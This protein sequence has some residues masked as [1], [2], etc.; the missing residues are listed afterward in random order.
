[1]EKELNFDFIEQPMSILTHGSKGHEDDFLGCCFALALYPEVTQILRTNEMITRDQLYDRNVI[2]MDVGGMYSR[3]R[4]AFDH[5]GVT[6]SE[7]AATLFLK[8]ELESMAYKKARKRLSD[9]A[10]RDNFGPRQ[11]MRLKLTQIDGHIP[12]SKI[13][14]IVSQFQTSYSPVLEAIFG[15]W[16]D[17]VLIPQGSPMYVFM[18]AVGS[19]FLASIIVKLQR[20]ELLKSSAHFATVKRRDSIYHVLIFTETRDSP[21]LMMNEFLKTTDFES[22]TVA[23]ITLDPRGKGLGL[24]R[25]DSFSTIL[26]FNNIKSREMKF[27]HDSGFYATTKTENVTKALKII[28][29]AFEG[30]FEC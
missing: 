9:L 18:Q 7:C 1:M 23:T 17:A 25:Y 21:S 4:N 12:T 16:S 2:K 27:I 20:L 15:M 19:H 22:S 28:E 14:M 11:L 13:D 24:Y 8:R 3:Y 5:H 29:G 26:D 10:I 30:A 6:Q